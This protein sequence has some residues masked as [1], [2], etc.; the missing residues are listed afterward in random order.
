MTSVAMPTVAWNELLSPSNM[1]DVTLGMMNTVPSPS[2]YSNSSADS[3][4]SSNISM[5]SPMTIQL[6]PHQVIYLPD[7]A[8]EEML[9]RP[10]LKVREEP[11]EKFRFRYKSEMMGT[12]GSILG[13]NS[14]KNRKKSYPSVELCNYSGPAVIRC[15]LYTAHPD[16]SQRSPH[17]HRLVVRVDN[18]DKDDPHDIIVSREVGYFAVFQGMGIIH[19]AKKHITDELVKKKRARFLEMQKAKN[20]NVCSLS[21]KEEAQ[22]RQEAE[23]EA[24]KMNLNS[25]TLCFEAFRIDENGYYHSICKPVFSRTI[26]N[27]KSALTGELKI[28]RIDKHVSSCMGGEEVFILVEKVGKKNIK[29][30]FF[31]V[32]D[33]DNEIWCDY[34]KFS[35][36]DVH[37][38]YAIVFKTPPYRD[39]EIEDTREVFLQ[40]YRPT[41]GDCSEPIK[42]SYRPSD[43]I[44][45]SRKRQRS[46][47]EHNIPVVIDTNPKNFVNNTLNQ[48]ETSSNNVDRLINPLL[49]PVLSGDKAELLQQILDESDDNMDSSDFRD[50]VNNLSL[51]GYC[52]TLNLAEAMQ[53]LVT[54]GPKTKELV[55]DGQAEKSIKT[56]PVQPS[57]VTPATKVSSGTC[58]NPAI[59]RLADSSFDDS[60]LKFIKKE[61]KASQMHP[62][63]LLAKKTVEELTD[64]LKLKPPSE[65]L[66][67]KVSNIFGEWKSEAGDGPLHTAILNDQKDLLKQML[68]ILGRVNNSH[69]VSFRNFHAQTPL[70]V[71]VLCNQAD[72][73]KAL[74]SVGA[75][76]NAVNSKGDTPLHIAVDSSYDDC[77]TELLNKENYVISNYKPRLDLRNYRGWTPLHLAAKSNNLNAVKK[78]VAAKA[79]VNEVDSTYGR[80]V[81]HLAV[82]EGYRDIVEYL[83]KQT[84]VDV[85]LS[86]YAGNTALHIACVVNSPAIVK[87]LMD[88]KA[89]PH[90][91][92]YNLKRISEELE[93]GPGEE[94]VVKEEPQSEEEDDDDDDEG[95]LRIDDYEED[96]D[97]DNERDKERKGHTSFDLASNNKEILDLLKKVEEETERRSN[98]PELHVEVKEE[99]CDSPISECTISE[100]NGLF[101]EET[102]K[103]VCECLDASKGWVNLADLL[104][105]SF[106]VPNIRNAT[107]PSKLLLNYAD[108]HGSVTVQDIRNFLEALDE[109]RAVEIID[110]MLTRQLVTTTR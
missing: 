13:R 58:T 72:S 104:D 97:E 103:K 28:C 94:I 34:G 1:S 71:A 42:F 82:E 63:D 24:K 49:D 95:R 10:Y 56:P 90:K 79:D 86:N 31:E 70:H 35:E 44:G 110:L 93:K 77:I 102:F 84:S 66:R 33:E 76:P 51:S 22:I 85:N 57:S 9:P 12:H 100:E 41:D 47:L 64:L 75:D 60:T 105:Y 67:V 54:D 21:T 55:T 45:R 25:V 96:E 36:L 18:D 91:E 32:D 88:S 48:M 73:A 11:V 8:M 16:E 68:I 40:L 2:S 69:I 15:S 26:N 83:V 106:L 74:L 65:E 87:L 19:T 23:Q 59:T 107:S 62:S 61:T 98:T 50:F 3:Q 52:D 81:L 29:I 39:L 80:T 37:H 92:N 38:Q 101:D 14:D 4:E 5:A 43:K 78:L 99:M 20:I 27:M 53:D 17:T 6:S 109:H 89:D 30:K 46:S 108:L 7:S